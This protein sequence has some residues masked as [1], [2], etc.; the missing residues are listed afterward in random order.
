[1]PLS[2]AAVA[3]RFAPA[4]L[5]EVRAATDLQDR[6]ER[7][8]VVPAATFAAL[9][10]ALLGTHVVLEIGGLRAFGYRTTYLDTPAL[11]TYR[12]HLQRRRR[13]FKC[14]TREY[15][16]SGLRAFEVK[17]KGLRGRTVKRRLEGCADPLAA[18]DFL[19]ACLL[20]AYGRVVA[21]PFAPALAVGYTRVT[22]AAPGRA[23]RLT[24]DARL[25]FRAPGGAAAAM[26]D[27]FV[28]LESKSLHGGALADR[29]LR[30]LGARPEPACSK[31]CLG[32][33]LTRPHLASNPLRP[34]LR[35]HFAA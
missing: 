26:D 25:R 2:P 9:A 21:E 10:E 29:V 28:I 8:Y 24:C 15:A 20:E 34:L 3:E 18:A 33:A 12:E 11:L 16:D 30:G 7:K 19:G 35:R 13:R 1:M 5:D 17:L 27:G 14:R 22:L 23:E 4:G 31:Y 6:Q 32:V